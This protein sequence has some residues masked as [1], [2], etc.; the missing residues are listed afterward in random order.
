[1]IHTGQSARGAEYAINEQWEI[2]VPKLGITTE[3]KD[4]RSG[5]IHCGMIRH[6][7]QRVQF[8]VEPRSQEKATVQ[9][10][11]DG[12]KAAEQAAREA[13]PMY[14]RKR[15]V[16]ELSRATE[17]ANDQK[18]DGYWEEWKQITAREVEPACEALREFD[19]ANP[20]TAAQAKADRQAERQADED[21]RQ[22]EYEASFIGRGID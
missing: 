12:K 2:A 3:V 4:I 5:M 18:A 22:R 17:K 19:E 6:Q 1:M 15:L 20:E 21:R 8:Q 16:S 13:D 10:L 11:W 14:Q 7:G 9:R